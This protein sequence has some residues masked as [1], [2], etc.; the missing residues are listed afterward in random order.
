MRLSLQTDFALRTL[1]YLACYEKRATVDEVAGFYG[2]SAAHV[3]KVVHQLAR[4]GYVRSIRGVGGGVELSRRAEEIVVGDVVLAFERSMQLLQCVD[5][6]GVCAIESFCKLKRVLAEAERVQMEY[7]QSVTLHD[8]LP[9]R[10][11]V[12]TVE[13]VSGG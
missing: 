10:R 4:L 11:Q 2:I 3:G 7:L 8:V 12:R 9:T 5:T 1:I 13:Q 6:D